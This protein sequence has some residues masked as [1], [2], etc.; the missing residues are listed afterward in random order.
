MGLLC[1]YN[2][3]LENVT[4]YTP[5]INFATGGHQCQSL[6]RYRRYIKTGRQ[7]NY[8]IDYSLSYE[9]LYVST[10]HATLVVSNSIFVGLCVFIRMSPQT[11]PGCLLEY[12]MFFLI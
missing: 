5:Y 10:T 3:L 4:S 6:K 1:L 9:I 8:D 2:I 12:Y 7:F 11:L